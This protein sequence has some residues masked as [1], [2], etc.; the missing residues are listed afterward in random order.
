MIGGR[1]AVAEVLAAGRARQ[2]ELR[3]ANRED[4]AVPGAPHVLYA[5]PA[6]GRPSAGLGA[7]LHAGLDAVAG[8]VRAAA[9]PP[10]PARGRPAL[11]RLPEHGALLLRELHRG[12]DIAIWR[13]AKT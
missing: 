11:L 3:L 5:L 7:H 2:A 12:P 13:L 1:P 8:A 10:V 6:P 4:A 9:H